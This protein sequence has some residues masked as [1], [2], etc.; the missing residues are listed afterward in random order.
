MD[1][2][3]HIGDDDMYKWPIPRSIRAYVSKFSDC[4]NFGEE[5]LMPMA[6]HYTKTVLSGRLPDLKVFH[7][8][9]MFV[10]VGAQ[11]RHWQRRLGSKRV[12]A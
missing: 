6:I 1:N 9:D 4:D 10:T 2:I 11:S 12:P 7:Y 8:S 5:A 3:P